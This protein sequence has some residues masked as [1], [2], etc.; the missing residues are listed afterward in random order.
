MEAT[1]DGIA[2]G[3]TDCLE[4]LKMVHEKSSDAPG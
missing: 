2:S 1:E 3:V 4:R